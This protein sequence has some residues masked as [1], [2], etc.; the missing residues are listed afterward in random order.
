MGV[1][2]VGEG[3]RDA[4]APHGDVAVD[5][6]GEGAVA[7]DPQVGEHLVGIAGVRGDGFDIDVDGFRAF[8]AFDGGACPR[9]AVFVAFVF[10]TADGGVD[11]LADAPFGRPAEALDVV[12]EGGVRLGRGEVEGLFDD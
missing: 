4:V 9:P 8:D 3:Q 10:L 5:G 2:L 11:A 7:A 6:E 1:T 12:S